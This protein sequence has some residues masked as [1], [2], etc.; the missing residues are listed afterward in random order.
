MVYMRK[1]AYIRLCDVET[2]EKLKAQGFIQMEAHEPQAA[3]ETPKKA[4]T[5]EK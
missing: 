5:K 4:K 2:A 3:A 1:G